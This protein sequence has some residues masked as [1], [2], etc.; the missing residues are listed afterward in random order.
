M[1]Q[2]PFLGALSVLLVLIPFPTS[3]QTALELTVEQALERALVTDHCLAAGENR[4]AATDS[5]AAAAR[6]AR[7]PELS[8]TGRYARIEEQDPLS[9]ETPGGTTRVGESFSDSTA[10]EVA[11]MQPVFLGGRLSAQVEQGRA[12]AEAAVLQQLW[13]RTML[14][15][16][17]QRSYWR[18]VEGRLRRDA[19]VERR[20]QVLANLETVER[21]FAEGLV[22][23]NQLLKVEMRLAEAELG[24]VE[25]DNAL[26]LASADLAV[27]VGED[28]GRE[29]VP[30][31]SVP[32]RPDVELDLETLLRQAVAERPDLLAQRRELDAKTESVTIARSGFYPELFLTGNYTYARPNEA[33]FPPPD[34]FEDSWRVGVMGRLS[35]GSAP[36]TYHRAQEAQSGRTA[37]YHEVAAAEERLRLQIRRAF[38]AW[39]SSSQ[40]VR[41]GQ[42]MVRQAEENLANTG[43]RVDNG[44]ALI[45]DLLDAQADLL[46]ARLAATSAVVERELAWLEVMYTSAT[47]M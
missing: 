42:T 27:R 15:M 26:A 45:E 39:R 17:L 19:F 13:R 33:L 8:V 31:S 35:L 36:R 11:L 4:A 29:I 37:G 44:T 5:A 46:E 40:R 6:A 9:F 38:L 20:D 41:L 7:L 21:R 43:V 22:T 32:I 28:P 30:A 18:L 1:K 14:K 2:L 47:E 10:I 16:E 34:S 23:R 25:A 3:G 12:L 24:L